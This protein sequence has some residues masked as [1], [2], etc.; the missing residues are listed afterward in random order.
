MACD[1]L[2]MKNLLFSAFTCKKLLHC[3]FWKVF[4]SGTKL[5]GLEIN[6]KVFQNFPKN[7][8]RKFGKSWC[9]MIFT[10]IWVNEKLIVTWIFKNETQKFVTLSYQRSYNN[11]DVSVIW[12]KR[13]LIIHNVHSI[14]SESD[15]LFIF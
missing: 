15:F 12:I 3:K 11:N 13:R 10:L 2:F 6:E 8:V 4:F 7:D 9:L 1:S 14:Q 5:M